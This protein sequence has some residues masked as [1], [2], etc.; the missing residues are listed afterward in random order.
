MVNVQVQQM[1]AY[2]RLLG[3][4]ATTQPQRV[5]IL[6]IVSKRLFSTE[7]VFY[8][9]SPRGTNSPART[10]LVCPS[11]ATFPPRLLDR[12]FLSSAMISTKT[13]HSNN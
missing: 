13:G 9:D 5:L 10:S 11:S 3:L 7:Q 1:L 12:S 2:S 4:D 6:A 8:S